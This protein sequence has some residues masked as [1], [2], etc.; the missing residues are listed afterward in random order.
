[1]GKRIV[2]TFSK[3]QPA[4]EIVGVVGDEHMGPL[5]RRAAPAIYV[6]GDDAARSYL[7]IVARGN[8]QPQAMARAIGE[9][10]AGIAVY[11]LGTMSERIARQPWMF[12]RRF[13]AILVASFAAIALLLA[14]IGI[15]GVLAYTVRQ[16]THEIG[17]R[18]AIGAQGRHIA[19][20]LLGHSAALVGLGIGLG[21]AVALVATRMLGSVLFGVSPSDPLTLAAAAGLL[22]VVALAASWLP[23][24]RAMSVDPLEALRPG[25]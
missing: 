13:P 24:R 6:T 16:R 25:S 17:V 14:M 5:A 12:V 10:G 4:R 1:V 20:M 15:Y 21:L 22:L 8:V 23:A 18:R 3:D 9:V 2:F 19:S 7:A 11:G